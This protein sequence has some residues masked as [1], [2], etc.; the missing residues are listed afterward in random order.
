MADSEKSREELLQEITALKGAVAKL[1]HQLMSLSGRFNLSN[2]QQNVM[3]DILDNTPDIFVLKDREGRH[4]AMNTAFCEFM[5]MPEEEILGKT[6]FD[7][8]SKEEAEFYWKDDQRVMTERRP[9]I[10]D[11]QVTGKKGARWCQVSKEAVMDDDGKDVIGVLVT[12]RDITERKQ[13]EEKLKAEM[14]ELRQ[15]RV[16]EGILP[17]CASC[18]DIRDEEGDWQKVEHYVH[19]RAGATFSHCICPSCMSKLY[20]EF[21]E[22]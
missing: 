18:K 13:A 7:L 20:P 17:I 11:E 15:H 8:H 2:T 12:V 1:K 3:R 10:Q 21:S 6:D 4:K 14:E 5:G 9:Q 19:Q 22:S 16:L